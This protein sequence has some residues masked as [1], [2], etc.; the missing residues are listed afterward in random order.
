MKPKGPF[1]LRTDQ[2]IFG[3]DHR[4]H[5]TDCNT[6]AKEEHSHGPGFLSRIRHPLDMGP[7]HTSLS[8][9]FLISK[10]GMVAPT[11]QSCK[12]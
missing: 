1:F 6:T 11:S 4:P 2:T 10:T 8:L 9:D 7:S 5:T 12:D 3:L